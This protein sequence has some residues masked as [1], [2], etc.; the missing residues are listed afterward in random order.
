M[1]ALLWR[2]FSTFICLCL[3]KVRRAIGLA[4]SWC[5]FGLE[6]ADLVEEL[7]MASVICGCN[8]AKNKEKQGTA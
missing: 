3:I 1:Y 8:S 4:L 7:W 2:V 5:V 6:F